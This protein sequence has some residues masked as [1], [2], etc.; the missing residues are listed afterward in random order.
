MT[1]NYPK[2]KK[3]KGIFLLKEK[4]VRGSNGPAPLPGCGPLS[5]YF[6]LKK[7]LFS[8]ISTL[9]TD[10]LFFNRKIPLPFLAFWCDSGKLNVKFSCLTEK[11]I[12][13]LNECYFFCSKSSKQ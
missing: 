4:P 7:F 12:T 3:K 9:S 6:A 8:P 2:K 1:Q 13:Y 5:A 10:H 11:K